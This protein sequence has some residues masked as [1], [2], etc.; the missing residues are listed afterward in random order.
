MPPL[1][2]EVKAQLEEPQGRLCERALQFCKPSLES[3]LRCILKDTTT[4][5]WI[6]FPEFRIFGKLDILPA[7]LSSTLFSRAPPQHHPS[8]SKAKDTHTHQSTFTCAK[9]LCC[10]SKTRPCRKERS[11]TL[12]G[13]PWRSALRAA[14]SRNSCKNLAPSS[15]SKIEAK[16]ERSFAKLFSKAPSKV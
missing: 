1:A 10:T 8:S 5:L 6:R 13:S 12:S 9:T 7:T 3:A 11:H 14:F 2:L 4:E 16:H 15:L